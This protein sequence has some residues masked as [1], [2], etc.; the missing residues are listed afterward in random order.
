[1]FKF[2]FKRS[3]GHGGTVKISFL[4]WNYGTGLRLEFS[5]KDGNPHRLDGPA[6][7]WE[8]GDLSWFI[9]G[10]YYTEEPITL[11]ISV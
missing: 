8:N 6:I 2:A 10:D 7:V 4:E 3:L 11:I 5:D 9:N 1:M